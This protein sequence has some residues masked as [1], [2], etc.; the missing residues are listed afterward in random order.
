MRPE[1]PRDPLAGPDS[2]PEHPFPLRLRGEVIKGFGRGSKEVR[3]SDSSMPF[4]SFARTYHFP[5]FK[6]VMLGNLAEATTL[7]RNTYS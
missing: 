7:A 6:T 5:W 4:N 3:N 1:R 2:G